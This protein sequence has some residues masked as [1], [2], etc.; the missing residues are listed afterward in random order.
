MSIDWP[1]IA[2]AP[3]LAVAAATAF[4]P[5][6]RLGRRGRTAAWLAA[7]AVVALSPGLIPWTASPWRFASSLIA[8]TLLVKLY[9]V[10]RE[11]RHAL[12]MRLW[13]YLAYLPNGFWLVLRREPGSVPAAR[14]VRRLA[15]AVP[16]SLSCI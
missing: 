9:D 11:A 14:D 15:W 6:R 7:S 2:L 1:L 4:Y 16:A 13:A 5:A 3:I 12:R 8:I 10:H